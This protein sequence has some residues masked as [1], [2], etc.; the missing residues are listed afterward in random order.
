MILCVHRCGILVF[1]PNLRCNQYNV[2]RF[3]WI[4]K[5]KRNK[6]FHC[7]PAGGGALN[8][9]KNSKLKTQKFLAKFV[10]RWGGLNSRPRSYQERALPLSYIGNLLMSRGEDSNPQPSLY[11]SVAL[12]LSYLG[13]SLILKFIK[14]TKLRQ[15]KGKCQILFL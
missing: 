14:L 1:L 10:S 15:I 8:F 11:K 5:Y 6:T 12:P 4:S 3:F 13:K 7:C 2:C 9:A